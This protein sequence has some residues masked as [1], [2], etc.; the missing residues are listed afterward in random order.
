MR[1][2]FRTEWNTVA[3]LDAQRRDVLDAFGLEAKLLGISL[4]YLDDI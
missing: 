2:S 1:L 4:Q 3:P